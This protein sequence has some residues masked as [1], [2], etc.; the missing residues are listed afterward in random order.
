MDLF[1]YFATLVF[2]FFFLSHTVRYLLIILFDYSCFLDSYAC[3]HPARGA[4]GKLSEA[5]SLLSQGLANSFRF[6]P[7]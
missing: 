2:F 1:I 4:V 7:F 5:L 6:S 3:R